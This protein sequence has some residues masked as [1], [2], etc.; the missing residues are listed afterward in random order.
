[1]G[2]T[3]EGTE[4]HLLEVFVE[5]DSV[6]IE[7]VEQVVRAVIRNGDAAMREEGRLYVAFA[8]DV[9]GAAKASR[10]LMVMTKKSG[11]ATR[12]RLVVE[13]FPKELWNVVSKVVTGVAKVSRRIPPDQKPETESVD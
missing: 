7:E 9:R 5:S 4:F 12:Y 1:M 6:S 8:G 3:S 11:L 2:T 13:P 10:R